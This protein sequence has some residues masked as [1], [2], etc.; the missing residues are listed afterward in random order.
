MR[1][2]QN[3]PGLLPREV[4]GSHPLEPPSYLFYSLIT[5]NW[6]SDIA[7]TASSL[8]TQ[9][10]GT[11]I[12]ELTHHISR[13]LCSL[14]SSP[15]DLSITQEA[16]LLG[17]FKWR[18]DGIQLLSFEVGR[19]RP[20][21]TRACNAVD[22]KV[23][24]PP[25][26]LYGSLIQHRGMY[27]VS[28][29]WKWKRCGMSCWKS[30]TIHSRS[31]IVIAWRWYSQRFHS[32]MTSRE[33]NTYPLTLFGKN[34]DLSFLRGLRCQRGW[35]SRRSWG[36][37]ITTPTNKMESRHSVGIAS[38]FKWDLKKVESTQ[39]IHSRTPTRFLQSQAGKPLFNYIYRSN[40]NKRLFCKD[41][42]WITQR[43]TPPSHRLQ[44]YE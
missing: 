27:S 10:T 18:G 19:W 36:E 15:N 20:N 4:R 7:R 1:C 42:I 16:S 44:Q 41:G 32:N 14:D 5:N 30:K 23:K 3:R 6:Q 13:G 26:Y 22:P 12:E 17:I 38:R 33:V 9:V 31:A 25:H 21:S 24:F 34:C 37:F 28:S 43:Q 11:S 40:F 39:A 8:R 35:M 2:S 29:P